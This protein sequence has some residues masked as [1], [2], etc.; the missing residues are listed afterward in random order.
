MWWQYLCSFGGDGVV[1]VL[2][3]VSNYIYYAPNKYDGLACDD[4]L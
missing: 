4:M 2:I 1:I 3:I